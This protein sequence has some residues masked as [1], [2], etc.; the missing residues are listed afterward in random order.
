MPTSKTT[1]K[2]AAVNATAENA[3][4]SGVL[5]PDTATTKD[6]DWSWMQSSIATARRKS[7]DAWMDARLDSL[8]DS[9][10]DYQSPRSRLTNLR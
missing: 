8:V 5:P 9:L 6:R 7:F 10:S 4:A 3:P 2:A 1:P